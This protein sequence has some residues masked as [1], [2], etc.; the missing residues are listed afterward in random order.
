MS[1]RSLTILAVV[2]GFF[3]SVLWGAPQQQYAKVYDPTPDLPRVVVINKA[4]LD[5]AQVCAEPKTGDFVSC[6][7]VGEFRQWVVQ[8]PSAKK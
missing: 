3:A 2:V 6:R 7:S 4:L 5:S 8:R 1:Y